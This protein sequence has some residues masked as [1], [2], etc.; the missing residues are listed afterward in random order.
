MQNGF[1][2]WIYGLVVPLFA[3]V[4]QA[5]G[6]C[7]ASFSPWITGTVLLGNKTS[8]TLWDSYATW[9][10]HDGV[11]GSALSPQILAKDV[12]FTRVHQIDQSIFLTHF[13][14]RI[15]P[16]FIESKLS[17]SLCQGNIN[18][19]VKHQNKYWP[20]FNTLH[21]F[22]LCS[23]DFYFEYLR[24]PPHLSGL[25]HYVN[26]NHLSLV[27]PSLCKPPLLWGWGLSVLITSF[28]GIFY[29]STLCCTWLFVSVPF[30]SGLCFPCVLR[31]P[32]L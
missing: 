5:N 32:I 4:S 3:N 12:V 16:R 6:T 9:L 1:G 25:A 10:L 19:N 31:S 29:I 30:M 20:C 21:C 2:L 18:T 7:K 27:W 13:L 22:I 23:R 28:T 17:L 15:W 8:V 11:F 14:I 24:P 26:Y